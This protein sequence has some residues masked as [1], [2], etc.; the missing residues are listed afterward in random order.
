MPTVRVTSTVLPGLMVRLPPSLMVNPSI[1]YAGLPVASH[2]TAPL[3]VP[4]TT[5]ALALLV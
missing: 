2:T 4:E 1:R 3:I 5:S